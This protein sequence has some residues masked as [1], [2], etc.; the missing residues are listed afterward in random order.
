[1]KRKAIVRNQTGGSEL[2]AGAR[3]NEAE[4]K[5]KNREMD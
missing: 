2:V 3:R 1:M 5:N 4:Q